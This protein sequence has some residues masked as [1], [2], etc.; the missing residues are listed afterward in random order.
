MQSS[1]D[2]RRRF[3]QSLQEWDVAGQL[4]ARIV[5]DAFSHDN[6]AAAADVICMVRPS[7]WAACAAAALTLPRVQ[8]AE[9]AAVAALDAKLLA[10]LFE[11]AGPVHGTPAAPP[12]VD[13]A[14]PYVRTR[15]G[16]EGAQR[17]CTRR[18]ACPRG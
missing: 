18:W 3:L 5:S 16:G 11:H 10:P 17:L 6:A 14:V 7:A 12:A 8:I 4:C 2:A 1:P 15:W 9:R 13:A